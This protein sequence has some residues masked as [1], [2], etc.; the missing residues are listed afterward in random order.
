MPTLC[1]EMRCSRVFRMRIWQWKSPWKVQPRWNTL[2]HLWNHTLKSFTKDNHT[3]ILSFITLKFVYYC[4]SKM[5]ITPLKISAILI[6][7]LFSIL[8]VTFF[9]CDFQCEILITAQRNK[10]SSRL[11][12]D[13]PTKTCPE[14]KCLAISAKNV[15]TATQ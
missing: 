6:S 4:Y 9:Q 1:A 8:S 3:E 7:L 5:L 11:P 2:K 15:Y 14:K 12:R 13:I 10:M